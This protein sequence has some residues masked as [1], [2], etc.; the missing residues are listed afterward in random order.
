MET[1]WFFHTS[2]IK[3]TACIKGLQSLKIIRLWGRLVDPLVQ[4]EFDPP[5]FPELGL[6]LKMPMPMMGKEK[7]DGCGREDGCEQALAGKE[8]RGRLLSLRFL[9]QPWGIRL[10][11][12]EFLASSWGT[13]K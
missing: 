8:G 5:T 3:K 12:L 10:N 6:R 7:A 1:S 13:L 9:G 4:Y 11:F 2:L